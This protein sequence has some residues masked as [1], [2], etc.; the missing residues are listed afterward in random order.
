MPIDRATAIVLT[1]SATMALA[2]LAAH[3]RVRALEERLGLSVLAVTGLP[4]LVLGLLYAAPAVGVLDAALL[5]DLRPAF[6][7]ALG[8]I[9]FS[10]GARLDV[11]RL[12]ALPAE[13]A[14]AVAYTAAVPMLLTAAIAA[15]ILFALGATQGTGLVRDVIVLAASAAASAPAR[16]QR[17]SPMLRAVTDV[18]EVL[19]LVLL[20]SVTLWFRP[21]AAI[22]SWVLPTS[23]WALVLL[24]L[25]TMLGVLTHV[26]LRG[27]HDAAERIALL[28]GAVA[29]TAGIAGYL[30]LSIPV[31]C[32]LAGAILVNLP[33][34]DDDR[35]SDLLPWVERPLYLMLLVVVGASWDPWHWQGLALAAAF[36][37]GRVGGKLIGVRVAA[38]GPL[39]A[40]EPSLVATTL[41]PQSPIAIVVIVAAT[42]SWY[43]EPPPAAHWA[44]TAVI[45]GSLVAEVIARG[46]APRSHA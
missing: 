40:D 19:S 30:A 42:S 46:F 5:D 39:R 43:G 27:G 22:T 35:L 7:F 25:G 10:V 9:G 4:F 41:I 36:V 38:R 14:T 33:V 2:V 21:D 12:E 23:G 31:V 24:G 16:V 20:G 28:V 34:S 32:A 26:L 18:D 8:W 29:L 15:P 37:L 45:L 11:R 3:P 13:F 44:I 1:L 6:D 17:L